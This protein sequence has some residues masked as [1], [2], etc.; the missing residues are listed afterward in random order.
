VHQPV[1]IVDQGV[2]QVEVDGILD[3]RVAPLLDVLQMAGDGVI[4]VSVLL[5]GTSC[6]LL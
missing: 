3:D 5:I 1:E 4:H 2:D 6:S